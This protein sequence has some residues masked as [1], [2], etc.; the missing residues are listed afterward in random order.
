MITLLSHFLSVCLI[1]AQGRILSEHGTKCSYVLYRN[2][3]QTRTIELW[4]R[5]IRLSWY[6]NR[7]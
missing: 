5:W 3:D 4:N 7:V 2:I 1:K 6:Y